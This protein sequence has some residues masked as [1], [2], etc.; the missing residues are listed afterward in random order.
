MLRR[1]NLRPEK[2]EQL[3]REL[4]NRGIPCAI[5]SPGAD[6][7]VKAPDGRR[8]RLLFRARGPAERDIRYFQ[9]PDLKPSDD[10]FIV[11]SD[12]EDDYWIIPSWVFR[13]YATKLGLDFDQAPAGHSV[14]RREI[15]APY[16]NN[17]NLLRKSEEDLIDLIAMYEALAAPEEERVAWEDYK[18]A[19]AARVSGQL[20][21]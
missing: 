10:L 11:G 17:W 5:D 12:G 20:P 4:Q 2:L 9:A 16:R 8:L 21:E 19:R 1:A 15:L 14:K 6:I 7:E 3:Q 13:K 18:K